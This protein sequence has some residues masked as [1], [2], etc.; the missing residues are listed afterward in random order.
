MPKS[1]KRKINCEDGAT[2]YGLQQWY[3]SMFEKLGWMVLA[4]SKGH[5]NDKNISYKLSLNRLEEKIICK[6]NTTFD[7]DKQTDLKL[8]LRDVRILIDHVHKDF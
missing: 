2:M 4:K 3:V 5:M 6:I 7:A 8:M 1:R